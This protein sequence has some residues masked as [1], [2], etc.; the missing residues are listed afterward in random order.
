MAKDTK[1]IF[2]GSTLFLK[3]VLLLL[4]AGAI[5]LGGLLLYL[6]ITAKEVGDYRPILLGVVISLLPFLYI[7]RQ[8]YLLL[9]LIDQ[10]LS[11]TYASANVLRRIKISSWVIGGIYLIGSPFVYWIAERDD[12]PGVIVINI[13][14]IVAPFAVGVFASILQ[15]LLLNAIG[16]KSENELTI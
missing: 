14:L 13:I 11:L 9:N 12:A 3:L 1:T 6:V 4:G 7:F 5:T 8:S 10:N 2:K 15:K 16:Y